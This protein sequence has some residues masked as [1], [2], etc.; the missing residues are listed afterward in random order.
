MVI[1][2][3][4]CLI[5][6]WGGAA[7][8]APPSILVLGDSLSAAYGIDTRTGWVNLL[9]ERL[10]DEGLE[11]RVV[12]A[13]ISGET[14]EGGRA[15]LPAALQDYRPQVVIIALGGNDGL[16]GLP[17]SALRD[18]LGAMVRASEAAGARVLLAGVRLPP[19]YG[20]AYTDKF[21]NVY[22]EVAAEHEVASVPRLLEGV[23]GDAAQM[24]SDGLHPREN[25][26]AR[27]LDNLWPRLRPL[28]QED[29]TLSADAPLRR[30]VR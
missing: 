8:A 18:N 30:A 22:Q 7:W 15:R 28:L 21:Q 9:Q 14:T 29:D 20:K 11:H 13:S 5:G 19:N 16:R 17:L 3:L 23:A 1:R 2:L 12:N 4:V 6:F 27:I 10:A 25:A 24:Q 26:Q